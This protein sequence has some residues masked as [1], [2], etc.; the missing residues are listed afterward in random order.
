VSEQNVVHTCVH[1]EVH[2][3]HRGDQRLQ[4]A[5]AQKKTKKREHALL[6]VP[7]EGEKK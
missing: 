5:R 4:E 3:Y 2:S 1:A 6:L 7:L